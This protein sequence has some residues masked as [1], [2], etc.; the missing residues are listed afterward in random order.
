MINYDIEFEIECVK[1]QTTCEWSYPDARE[2]HNVICS[3][4]KDNAKKSVKICMEERGLKGEP[5][6]TSCELRK[7]ENVF[8]KLI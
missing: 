7:G 5:N 4:V 6:I 8:F 3:K 2:L 1:H